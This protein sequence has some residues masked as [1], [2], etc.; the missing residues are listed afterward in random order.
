[1]THPI[2]PPPELSDEQVGKWLIDDG[3]PWDPSEQ[4]VITITTNRLK[5]VARQAFQAGA[6]QELDACCEWLMYEKD[7]QGLRAARRPKTQSL[8]EQALDVLHLSF[9]RGYLKEEAA[10]TIR[11]ALES[12]DD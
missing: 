9:D 6:D 5:N 2:T 7:R 10:D 3:Y 11:R 1:M 4:A 12:I 8:K